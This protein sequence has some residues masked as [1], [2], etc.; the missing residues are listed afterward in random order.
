MTNGF[1]KFT[2]ATR[3][4]KSFIFDNRTALSFLHSRLQQVWTEAQLPFKDVC[5]ALL[6]LGPVKRLE[7]GAA[8]CKIR[9]TTPS[10]ASASAACSSALRRSSA[11]DSS[12]R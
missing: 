7:L 5:T 8:A 10:S 12:C 3:R 6:D 9:P 4:S 2:T 11:R 1:S